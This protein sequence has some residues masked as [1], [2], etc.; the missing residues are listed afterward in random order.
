M[1]TSKER[2]QWFNN[3]RKNYARASGKKNGIIPTA[4]LDDPVV[5]KHDNTSKRNICFKDELE[6]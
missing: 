2:R 1:K 4:W 5:E 6:Q 3:M